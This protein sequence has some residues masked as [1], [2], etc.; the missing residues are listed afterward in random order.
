MIVGTYTV[1][2]YC[3]TSMRLARATLPLTDNEQDLSLAHR[4]PELR[5]GR[6]RHMA[7]V[8]GRSMAAC[9]RTLRTLGWR[10][11]H[12]EALCPGCVA[13]GRKLEHKEKL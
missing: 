2:A 1:H 13:D 9:L 3:R 5:D 4:F 7:D 12:G 6:Y 11:R 8:S 10:I